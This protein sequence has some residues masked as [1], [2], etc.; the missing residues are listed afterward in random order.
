VEGVG[1]GLEGEE[2]GAEVGGGGGGR[3]EKEK[4]GGL[5]THINKICIFRSVTIVNLCYIKLMLSGIK[6]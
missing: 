6:K 3:E 2:G 1:G 4:E 5:V